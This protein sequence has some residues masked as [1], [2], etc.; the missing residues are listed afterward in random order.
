MQRVLSWGLGLQSTT[1]A[2][3]SA[4][5]D[6]EQLD[7]I[8]T[9]DLGWERQK[10]YDILHFYEAWLTE[11]GIE[12]VVLKT[13]DIRT[14]GAQAHIHMP[15]FTETGAPLRRQCSRAFK[16][17][18][19]RRYLR[20][21][22]GFPAS[23]PPHPPPDSIEQWLGFSLDEMWR[24]EASDVKYI[25]NRFP[26]IE[27]NMARWDCPSYLKERGLPVPIKS[28]CIG[29]PFRSASEWLEMKNE[30][31]EEFDQG[32]AFDEANRHNPLAEREGSTADR[33][34]I[35]RGT[36]PLQDV[37]FE[38]EARKEKKKTAVQLPLIPVGC[39]SGLCHF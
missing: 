12:V 14:M 24:M 32:V 21:W 17:R 29:C 11:R 39:G 2:V 10:T 15:F 16:V 38:A 3:M 18:P 26:L 13:G 4:L 23:K 6:L 25:R 9:A 35:W 36:M 22:L 28:A 8:I 19:V 20:Q 5:G 34:Y 31:P 1:L 37:D 33:L 27:R 30:A 7:L